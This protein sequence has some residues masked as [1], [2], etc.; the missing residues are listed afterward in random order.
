MKSRHGFVLALGVTVV[1][2]FSPGTALAQVTTTGTTGSTLGTTGISGISGLGSG[3]NIGTSAGQGSNSSTSQAL[4]IVTPSS[5]TGSSTGAPASSNILVSTYGDPYS[6]G[7]PSIYSK[8]PPSRTSDASVKV[9]FGAA[10]YAN[11]GKS[12]AGQGGSASTTTTSTNYGTA[13]GVVRNPQYVTVLSDNVPLVVHKTSVLQSEVRDV[14]ARSERLPSKN[15]IQV[16]VSGNTV[17]LSGR[18]GSDRERL[19][20]EGIAKMTPGVRDV[21]N[22]LQVK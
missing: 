10:N 6:M 5:G 3:S 14:I 17:I 2:A 7:L 16:A 13:V 11:T 18:V 4:K 8:G 12:A 21:L 9:T 22:Q 20:A 1:I 15:D 19:V